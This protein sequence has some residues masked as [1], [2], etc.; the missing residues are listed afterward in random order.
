MTPL[1]CAILFDRPTHEAQLSV[2]DRKINHLCSDGISSLMNTGDQLAQVSVTFDLRLS[3][4]RFTL[5]AFAHLTFCKARS[6]RVT[7]D[8]QLMPSIGILCFIVI[9]VNSLF[10]LRSKALHCIETDRSKVF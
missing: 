9:G 5:T 8:A 10:I 6:N 7:Q 2:S 4:A 1:V 3:V